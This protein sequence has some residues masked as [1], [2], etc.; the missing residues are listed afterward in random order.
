MGLYDDV[1]TEEITFTLFNQI[2]PEIRRF[3]HQMEQKFQ[4]HDK[5]RGS[6]FQPSS[7]FFLYQRLA[8]EMTEFFIAIDEN[9]PPS[10]VVK[11]GADVSN[12]I[13]MI[14]ENYKRCK[15]NR[16]VFK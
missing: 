14:C 8:E 6:P 13:L 10:E 12:I 16:E 4:I 9:R 3:S 7:K 1:S 11:E 5:E 2:R 15:R